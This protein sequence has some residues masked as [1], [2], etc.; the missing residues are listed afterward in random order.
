MISKVFFFFFFGGVV[1]GG[2]GISLLAI[3]T[4]D[5][6]RYGVGHTAL[7]SRPNVMGNMTLDCIFVW[8]VSFDCE[9]SISPNIP[10]GTSIPCLQIGPV[11]KEPGNKV[12]FSVSHD[13]SRGELGGSKA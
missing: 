6:R 11:T 3:L 4:P 5:G 2:G 13:A 9:T 7:P 8:K 10:A 1:V 12:V